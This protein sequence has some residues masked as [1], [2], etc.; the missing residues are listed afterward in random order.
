MVSH[1]KILHCIK[2]LWPGQEIQ[3]DL[4]AQTPKAIVATMLTSPQAGSTTN[5]INQGA[6]KTKHRQYLFSYTFINIL[7]IHYD[8]N[9][10]CTLYANTMAST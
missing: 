8:S 9:M 3:M 10:L 1:L 6:I 2:K 7:L 4:K 5:S